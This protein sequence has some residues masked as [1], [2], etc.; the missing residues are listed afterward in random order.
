MI[1]MSSAIRIYCSVYGHAQHNI[2]RDTVPSPC[3]PTG[4]TTEEVLKVVRGFIV[5][6]IM[7]MTDFL[8]VQTLPLLS[9]HIQSQGTEEMH[10]STDV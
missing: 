7:A 9:Q 5:S 8:H 1:E 3:L 6:E 2:V 4:G 10:I